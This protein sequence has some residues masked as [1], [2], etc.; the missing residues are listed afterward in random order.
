MKGRAGRRRIRSDRHRRRG[1]GRRRP[2]RGRP[3][4]ERAAGGG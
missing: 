4:W 3:G 1:G 2:V